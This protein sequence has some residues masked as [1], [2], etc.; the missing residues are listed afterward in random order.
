MKKYLATIVV[1]LGSVLTSYSSIH[2]QEPQVPINRESTSCY[3]VEVTDVPVLAIGGKAVT[4]R[5][6]S[7]NFGRETSVIESF[8]IA[9]EAGTGI[10]EFEN[11]LGAVNY[12]SAQGW[13]VIAVNNNANMTR[14]CYLL[15]RDASLAPTRLT[16]AIDQVLGSLTLKPVE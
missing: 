6:V 10:I 2:A 14:V 15:R 3:Y 12:L 16:R 7:I 13:E 9:D 8:K 1:L 5:S 4:S 11:A